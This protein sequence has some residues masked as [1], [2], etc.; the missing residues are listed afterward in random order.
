MFIFLGDFGCRKSIP[1]PPPISQPKTKIMEPHKVRLM[2][3]QEQ[4]IE[5]LNKLESVLNS[6]LFET[7]DDKSKILLPIQ[8]KA[9]LTYLECLEQRIKIV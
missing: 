9:M 6:T 5:K 4:L 8:Y 1:T 3:E 7:F 2:I